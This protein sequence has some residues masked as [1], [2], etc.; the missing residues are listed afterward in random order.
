[1][2]ERAL[3][4]VL[5]IVGALFLATAYPMVKMKEDESLQM[6]FSLYV[7]LGI[8][9]LRAARDPLAHRSVIA[10]AGW[11]SFAHAGVMTTQSVFNAGE[12]MHLVLGSIAFGAIG[13]LLVALGPARGTVQASAEGAPGAPAIRTATENT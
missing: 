8:F 3:K 7:T 9:L 4:V 13:A 5:W 2:R 10:F 1:M 11:S 6:M 12:R